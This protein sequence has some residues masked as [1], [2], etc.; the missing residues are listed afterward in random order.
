MNRRK[1]LL[2]MVMAPFG[3]LVGK[4]EPKPI[5]TEADLIAAI[6]RGMAEGLARPI[7]RGTDIWAATWTPEDV[8]KPDF[9]MTMRIAG[10]N[11]PD[12]DIVSLRFNGDGK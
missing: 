10:Y 12:N 2:A 1:V 11:N 8:N 4:V 5:K 7:A 6:D 3:R 9:G